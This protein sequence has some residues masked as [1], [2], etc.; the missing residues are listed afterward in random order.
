MSGMDNYKTLSGSFSELSEG[1]F[2]ISIRKSG[3]LGGVSL[4]SFN[5]KLSFN[6]AIIL[7]GGILISL[8]VLTCVLKKKSKM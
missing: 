1:E 4:I 7:S 6:N 8:Y 2:H 5:N 3:Q